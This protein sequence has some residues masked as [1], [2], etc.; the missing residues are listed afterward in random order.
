MEKSYLIG[1]LFVVSFAFVGC[2][3]DNSNQ[4][5]GG[6]VI[7][8]VRW[9]TRNVDA[10]GTFADNPEDFGRFYQWNSKRAWRTRGNRVRNWD[11]SISEGT[12]W[13]AENDPCPKGWRV[14]TT[15][16]LRSLI[17]AGS[18]SVRQNERWGY[19]FGTAPYQIFLPKA[20]RRSGDSV[21]NGRG[22][23]GSW[24]YY[25]SSTAERNRAGFMIFASGFRVRTDIGI[26]RTLLKHGGAK[27]V[28][29]V[30]EN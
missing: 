14:P 15:E 1:L 22:W 16:E 8:G 30:A 29:C 23:M 27:S 24:G 28:R 25:W 7:N 26:Y 4:T 10:P 3:S 2:N 6:V 9:A 17:D 20:G 13:Y 5:D 18:E 19:L 21:L 11:N 12:K